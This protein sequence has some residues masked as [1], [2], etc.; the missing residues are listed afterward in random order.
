MMECE[1]S[2]SVDAQVIHVDFQPTLSNHISEDM[3]HEGLKG[4]WSITE[5]KEHDGGFKES[6]RGDERSFP[7]IFTN[8][9]VVESPSNIELGKDRGVFHVINQFRNE[10]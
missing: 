7:L 8:V 2:L 6:E 4:G 10:G 9:N 5:P 3:V 1:V